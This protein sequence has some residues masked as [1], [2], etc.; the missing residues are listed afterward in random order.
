MHAAVVNKTAT[1][2][3]AVITGSLVADPLQSTSVVEFPPRAFIASL[4]LARTATYAISAVPRTVQAELT[5]KAGSS[6]AFDDAVAFRR[7][8]GLAGLTRHEL[9]SLC[10]RTT[11]CLYWNKKNCRSICRR[12]S[13]VVEPYLVDTSERERERERKQRTRHVAPVDNGRQRPGRINTRHAL[14]DPSASVRPTSYVRV[15]CRLPRDQSS[16]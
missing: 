11:A 7:Q 8:C 5:P 6:A 14:H 10:R 16:V 13:V 12:R 3:C 1:Y 15:C 2:R 9:G 4:Q